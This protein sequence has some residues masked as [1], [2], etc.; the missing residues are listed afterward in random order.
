MRNLL[1]RIRANRTCADMNIWYSMFLVCVI[2]P[3]MISADCFM[4]TATV[5]NG[6]VEASGE[7]I[8]VFRLKGRIKV[9]TC[10]GGELTLYYKTTRKQIKALIDDLKS[11]YQ[12]RT[13]YGQTVTGF[14]T[15]QYG[16]ERFQACTESGEGATLS[17]GLDSRPNVVSVFIKKGCE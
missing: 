16:Q 6:A 3:T 12:G 1:P 11:F 8:P 5:K 2:A 13:I 15:D 17:I 7:S 4:T 10:E 9:S 14:E